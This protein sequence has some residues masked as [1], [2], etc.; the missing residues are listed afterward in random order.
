MGRASSGGSMIKKKMEGT[1]LSGPSKFCPRGE[2]DSS[3]VWGGGGRNI[4]VSDFFKD[5]NYITEHTHII[6]HKYKQIK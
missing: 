5:I 6:T 1:G 4:N 2:S 3:G